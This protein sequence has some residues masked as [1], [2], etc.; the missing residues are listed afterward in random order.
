MN[1]R[2]IALLILTMTAAGLCVRSALRHPWTSLNQCLDQPERYDGHEVTQFRE[3]VIG[4][5]FADGF[6][7]LQKD[8]PPVRVYCDTTGLIRGEF[9][10][11][12]ATFHRQGYLDQTYLQIATL[13]R[14]KMVISVLPAVLVVGLFM[15][16][17]RWNRRK[18]QIEPRD[19]A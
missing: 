5:L 8:G 6:E 9:V 2:R 13:R 16:R 11:I 14:E 12:R 15:C 4:K 18:F 10:G 3:P 1:K 19:R 17:F 7:L